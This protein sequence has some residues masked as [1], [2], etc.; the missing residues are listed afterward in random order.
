MACGWC[1]FSSIQK[2]LLLL[3]RCFQSIALAPHRLPRLCRPRILNCWLHTTVRQTGW[4]SERK[5]EPVQL[6]QRVGGTQQIKCRW[7]VGGDPSVMVSIPAGRFCW[8][9]KT[10]MLL[11][12]PT[13]KGKRNLSTTS[14]KTPYLLRYFSPPGTKYVNLILTSGPRS[15][16]LRRAAF[17]HSQALNTQT[18]LGC[19]KGTPIWQQ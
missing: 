15:R 7:T 5:K 8:S 16:A 19:R 1:Q 4:S 17:H 10:L 11:S 2:N 13:T 14:L 3:W 6:C 9:L 12:A 18:T